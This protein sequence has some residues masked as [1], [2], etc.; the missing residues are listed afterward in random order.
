ML[1][2]GV[3]LTTKD[4]SPPEIMGPGQETDCCAITA[5]E[6]RSAH[7]IHREAPEQVFGYFRSSPFLYASLSRQKH[8]LERA[9]S[10]GLGGE[11]VRDSGR[12]QNRG[13][14]R[15]PQQLLR[16]IK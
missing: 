7:Q 10:R 3:L 15:K 8:I 2:R 4:L 12:I 14:S 5:A 1:L 11:L 9:F 6:P 13:K 16:T